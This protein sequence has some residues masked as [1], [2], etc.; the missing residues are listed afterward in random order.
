MLLHINIQSENVFFRLICSL[1]SSL[2]LH[3]TENTVRPCHCGGEARPRRADT[4][5]VG[6]P[7]VE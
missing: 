6:L 3:V 5:K 4:E 2:S 7:S 1:L